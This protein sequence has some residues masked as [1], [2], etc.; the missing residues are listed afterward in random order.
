[1]T[2]F[3]GHTRFSLYNPKSSSWKAS[4]GSKFSSSEDYKNYLYSE[5]R[6]DVRAEIFINQSLPQIQLAS[7]GHQVKHIV[8]YSESLPMKYQILLEEACQKYSFLILDKHTE[9]REAVD[10][11]TVAS[12]MLK[13]GTGAYGLY[14][15]DD[16]DLLSTDY[17]DQMSQYIY[18]SNAGFIISLALGLTAMLDSNKYKNVK[19]SHWPMLAIGLLSVCYR[20]ADGVVIAPRPTPHNNADRENPVILDS[21]NISYLWVRHPG[22]DTSLSMSDNEAKNELLKD[23]QKYDPIMPGLDINSKFPSISNIIVD[24]KNYNLIENPF[25]LQFGKSFSVNLEGIEFTLRIDTQGVDGC[26]KYGALVSFSLS[27]AN[28]DSE[29]SGMHLS[30]NPNIGY[31]RYIEIGNSVLSKEYDFSLPKGVKCD[32]ITV[33]KWGDYSMIPTI[34]SLTLVTE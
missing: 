28:E 25:L 14:R 32:R 12:Y 16:D 23:M 7:N 24:T 27:G 33:R 30:T 11:H 9:N 4:N 6:L 2:V 8:S 34:Q 18:P 21:R 5:K 29:I 13:S 26:P 3:V 31:Y 22:Q 20:N 10:P 1:M 15:L 19:L 17:F